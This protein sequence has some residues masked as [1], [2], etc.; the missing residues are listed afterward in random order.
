MEPKK[1]SRMTIDLPAETH[2]KLKSF[3]AIK[4]KSMREM[5][6]EMINERLFG[7]AEEDEKSR[8]VMEEILKEYGPALEK[9]AKL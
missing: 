5:V 9:L 4:G 7:G 8:R 2:K 6:I 1:L 3:A